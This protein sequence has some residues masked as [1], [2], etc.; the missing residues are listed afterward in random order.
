MAD[1]EK[2]PA[3]A[4]SPSQERQTP[5]L[6]SDMHPAGYRE[7]HLSPGNTPQVIGPVFALDVKILL[8][9]MVNQNDVTVAKV[10]DIAVP[11]L[12]K[13]EHLNSACA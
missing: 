1:I 6:F 4:S 10:E 11:I 5:S 7:V 13:A 12:T 3:M 2:R 9:N 8:V